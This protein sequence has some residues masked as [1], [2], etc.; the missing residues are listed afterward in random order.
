MTDASEPRERSSSW[1]LLTGHGH[2]LVEIARNPQARL[3]DLSA[4]AGITERAVQLI[5]SDL[6]EAGY[7]TRY[8]E[9]RRNRYVV[10]PATAFRHPSQDGLPVGPFLDL[11]ATGQA[12][13]HSG[14][15]AETRSARRAARA[16]LSV[17]RRKPDAESGRDS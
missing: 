11:L 5:V 12:A 15:A 9:G 16:R 6:E 14:P 10:N 3:R 4:R 2:V 17:R 8:R 13:A 1:T 7:I